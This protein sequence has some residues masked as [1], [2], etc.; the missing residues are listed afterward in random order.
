MIFLAYVQFRFD[1][2][3]RDFTTWQT[4]TEHI[5]GYRA[6]LKWLMRAAGR[7][8]SAGFGSTKRWS[9]RNWL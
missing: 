7:V 2:S 1:G 9:L 8:E 3:E 4:E 6:T 5:I